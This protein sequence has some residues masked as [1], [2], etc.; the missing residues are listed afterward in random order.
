M[1]VSNMSKGTS[2]PR[3]AFVLPP[4]GK[5]REKV[6]FFLSLSFPPEPPFKRTDSSRKRNTCSFHVEKRQKGLEP[7]PTLFFSRFCKKFY[8]SLL[9]GCLALLYDL[10]CCLPALNFLIE[11]NKRESV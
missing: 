6:S 4:N 9:L 7:E 3:R 5:D 10:V 2:G 1:V 8:F 11:P